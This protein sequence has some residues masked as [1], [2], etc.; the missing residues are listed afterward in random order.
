MSAFR[1]FVDENADVPAKPCMAVFSSLGIFSLNPFVAF[2]PFVDEN[3]VVP[4]KA[5]MHFSY[6]MSF[7][8]AQGRPSIRA[9][10]G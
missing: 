3:A 1:P 10:C 6:H 2:K 5:G 7:N 9:V 8:N 4:G